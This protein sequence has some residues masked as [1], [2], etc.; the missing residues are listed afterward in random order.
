MFKNNETIKTWGELFTSILKGDIEY[1]K[2]QK[3]IKKK[4]NDK[5]AKERMER[6]Y[7]HAQKF[8]RHFFCHSF[9]N[10]T[11]IYYLNNLKECNI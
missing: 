5:I 7:K 6:H 2:F 8:N 4:Y 9:Q 10:F 11:N 1:R 3:K